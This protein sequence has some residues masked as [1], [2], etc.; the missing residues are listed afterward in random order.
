MLRVHCDLRAP[1]A[2]QLRPLVQQRLRFVLRR[3]ADRVGHVEIGLS[4]QNGPRGGRDKR[5]RI[6]LHGLP[7]A[8]LVVSAVSGDWRAALDLAL[9]RV[10]QALRRQLQRRPAARDRA[11][12]RRL[13]GLDPALA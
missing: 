12:K 11:G 2:A 13:A 10:A 7:G 8:P 3:L 1:E 9:G 4:D 5:C 6:A